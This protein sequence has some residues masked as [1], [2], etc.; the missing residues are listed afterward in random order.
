MKKLGNNWIFRFRYLF[1]LCFFM[2]AALIVVYFT[3]HGEGQSNSRLVTNPDFIY[4]TWKIEKLYKN[5]KLVVNSNK[6]KDLYLQINKNGT[7]EWI[8]GNNRLK[9]NFIITP[10]GNQIIFDDGLR[11]EEIETVF[12]LRQNVLRFGKKN[13]NSHYEYVFTVADVNGGN[14]IE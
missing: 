7:A 11:I 9:F 2:F 10:D 14:F 8:K 13:I 5:G 12:E 4:N 1:L 3:T 6:Y